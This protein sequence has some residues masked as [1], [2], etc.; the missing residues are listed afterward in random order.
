MVS[1]ITF[2]DNVDVDQHWAVTRNENGP[3]MVIRVVLK[4]HNHGSQKPKNQF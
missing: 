3:L 2:E 1:I 4:I